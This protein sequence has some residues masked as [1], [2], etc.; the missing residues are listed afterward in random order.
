MLSRRSTAGENELEE[1]LP[2]YKVSASKVSTLC[3][4]SERMSSSV[5][6]RKGEFAPVSAPGRAQI[7]CESTAPSGK[8]PAISRPT[9][10]WSQTL[11]EALFICNCSLWKRSVSVVPSLL[12]IRSI[13][14]GSGLEKNCFQYQTDAFLPPLHDL[15]CSEKAQKSPISLSDATAVVRAGLLISLFRLPDSTNWTDEHYPCS[16]ETWLNEHPTLQTPKTRL[17]HEYIPS[18][19]APA[20]TVH[21]ATVF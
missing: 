20:T 19:G 14:V 2:G 5:R 17:T 10:D 1:P 13:R 3:L 21:V 18:G 11:N 8:I 12:R 4:T 7:F 16:L 6:R 9:K 15:V